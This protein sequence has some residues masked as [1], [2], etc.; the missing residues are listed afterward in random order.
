MR[1]RWMTGP[2][3]IVTKP[4]ALEN[5]LATPGI[6]G[7]WS[8]VDIRLFISSILVSFEK[9]K[10]IF[11]IPPA[12]SFIWLDSMG[13]AARVAYFMVNDRDEGLA[14]SGSSTLRC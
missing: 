10:K 13:K 4:L 2:K 12:T 14:Y 8:F 5:D 3:P 1:W 9:A 7:Q 6:L 11:V